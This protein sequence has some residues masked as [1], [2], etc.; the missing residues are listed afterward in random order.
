MS[1]ARHKKS[2]FWALCDADGALICV[3]VYKRGAQ[4]VEKRLQLGN[5]PCSCRQQAHT[6]KENTGMSEERI[7]PE[8]SG[9]GGQLPAWTPFERTGQ[10]V[11]S[12][13]PNMP[14][15]EI[16]ENSR[17]VIV[18][19]D[20]GG[21]GEGKLIWL[22][23]KNADNSARH[24]WREMQRIKNELVG[25]DVEAV[26]LYPAERRLVDG[27]NQFH[28]WAVVGFRFPFGF[29]ERLVSEDTPGVT[30]R[31]F[32]KDMRPADLVTVQIEGLAQV[33]PA[34]DPVLEF[35]AGSV[36]L[37]DTVRL[38]LDREQRFP[39]GE[40]VITHDAALALHNA[41]QT[42][43]LY[44]LRHLQGDWGAQDD[45]DR[46]AND[47][48]LENG[49]RLLSCYDLPTGEPIWIITEADRTT[50]SILTPGEY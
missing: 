37:P 23:I 1:I 11:V 28:L 35:A 46:V 21:G 38:P 32:E 10:V 17:Y 39:L 6:G 22:S 3:C 27:S 26:E 31:P 5:E 44:L 20:V 47:L 41:G 7:T 36:P 40:L 29:E 2:R 14:D 24:D 48:A 16:W 33:V 49:E 42:A 43:E 34:D 50:T 18:R 25:T 45:A 30:Q 15:G 13:L 9:T 4:E 19:R 12:N 8:S